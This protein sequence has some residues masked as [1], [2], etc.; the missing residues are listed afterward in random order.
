MW[1]SS[2]NGGRTAVWIEQPLS[3]ESRQLQFYHHIIV[4]TPQNDDDDDNE[5]NKNKNEND[6]RSPPLMNPVSTTALLPTSLVHRSSRRYMTACRLV[7]T[8]ALACRLSLPA[9]AGECRR[10]TARSTLAEGWTIDF[11]PPVCLNK[12]APLVFSAPRCGEMD[13]PQ[14]PV[15]SMKNPIFCSEFIG[16]AITLYTGSLRSA[17]SLAS[18]R[19]GGSSPSGA[20]RRAFAGVFIITCNK[21]IDF[22]GRQRKKKQE[23]KN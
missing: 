17:S 9:L 14:I 2:G 3:L 6:K 22:H 19:F 13:T 8:H 20:G 4:V 7:S 11:Q 12:T 15:T 5:K 16:C 21:S 10:K 1:R 23:R 18:K